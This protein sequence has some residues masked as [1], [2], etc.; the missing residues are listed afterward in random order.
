VPRTPLSNLARRE[1]LSS[2]FDGDG[3]RTEEGIGIRRAFG[4]RR[5]QV[6]AMVLRHALKLTAIGPVAGVAG[7][8][9]VDP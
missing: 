5:S 4:P 8:I 7:G 1:R 9:W 6:L 2:S 3:D